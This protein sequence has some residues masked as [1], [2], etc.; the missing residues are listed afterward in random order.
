MPHLSVW[1]DLPPG[2]K[3][4]GTRSCCALLPR[5]ARVQG[6]GG[7]AASESLGRLEMLSWELQDQSDGL[8]SP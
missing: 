5:A 6:E 4:Q 8:E 1:V 7:D 3:V 2:G